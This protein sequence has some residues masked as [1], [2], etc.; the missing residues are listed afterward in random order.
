[1]RFADNKISEKG[2]PSNSKIW[3]NDGIVSYED[4]HEKK[5]NIWSSDSGNLVINNGYTKIKTRKKH[6]YK[7]TVETGDWLICSLDNNVLTRNEKK[8]QNDKKEF[9][10]IEK[11]K[12]IARSLVRP[13]NMMTD[14]ILARIFGYVLRDGFGFV[15]QKP[16]S[17]HYGNVFGYYEELYKIKCDI[18]RLNYRTGD[19][20]ENYKSHH[21]YV[22]EFMRDFAHKLMEFG[23]PVIKYNLEHKKDYKIIYKIPDWIIQGSKDIKREFL[24]GFM[25]GIDDAE[26]YLDD[27]NVDNIFLKNIFYV[28]I[29]SINKRGENVK[30]VGQLKKLF[31]EL[32][33]NTYRIDS[34]TTILI[35][36]SGDNKN[37]QNFLEI[38]CRYCKNREIFYEIM[39]LYLKYIGERENDKKQLDK[40]RKEYDLQLSYVRKYMQEQKQLKSAHKNHV[41]SSEENDVTKREMT[42]EPTR[43][44]PIRETIRRMNTGKLLNFKEW[45]NKVLNDF[46]FLDILR[47]EYVGYEQGYSLI[48]RNDHNYLVN[49]F[50]CL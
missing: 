23:Y 36:I 47:H 1:M 49:G 30:I 21:Y 12:N 48:V 42:R 3:T 15:S 18:E 28:P 19:I 10:E 45:K 5:G 14:C 13:Y 17:G 29:I 8:D 20:K 22:F 34:D 6:M 35:I 41:Y 32:N 40:F 26:D 43:N 16:K 39:L 11:A 44:G 46:I 24:A 37:I 7:T 9:V 50:V 27:D 33:V 2:I 38:G 25:S 31:E 4:L